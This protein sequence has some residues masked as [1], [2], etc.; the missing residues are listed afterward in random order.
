MLGQYTLTKRA[1]VVVTN[2]VQSNWLSTC[3]VAA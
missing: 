2:S 1:L 3:S